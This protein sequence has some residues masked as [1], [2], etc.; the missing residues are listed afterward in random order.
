MRLTFLAFLLVGACTTSPAPP[1]P[2]QVAATIE[3]AA[4]APAPRLPS[5][6]TGAR[7]KASGFATIL[8]APP[9]PYPDAPPAPPGEQESQ[10]LAR[11]QG[12]SVSHAESMMN[13]DESAMRAAN[14][15]RRRLE[16]EAAGNY[17]DVQIVRD[18]RPR[19]QFHFRSDGPETLARFTRDPRFKGVTGGVAHSELAP[20]MQQWFARFEPY[21]LS[22]A[23][24]ANPFTGMIEIEIAVGASE[25]EAIAAR[26]GWQLP[27][28][29][30]LK[31]QPEIDPATTLAPDAAPFV[32]T[33]PRAD[34]APAIIL[35]SASGGRII[36]HDGCFRMNEPDGPLVLFGRNMRLLRDDQGYLALESIGEPGKRA[37]IGEEM[38]W[39]GYPPGVE[40][41]PGV[42]AIRRHCGSGPIA[43]VGEPESAAS[44]RVRSHAIAAYA[45]E[46]RL[47][48]Q[49][50]W[51]EIKACWAAQ[52][53]RRASARPSDSPP[54]TKECDS[55][56]PINPPPPARRR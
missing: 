33:F 13:P 40:E 48:L 46:R 53:A 9:V 6:P 1:P 54:Y 31:F 49:A 29:V 24:G 26:E 20:V 47:T 12:V 15:L 8:S 5:P 18:P 35:T 4:Q 21:R 2:V 25:Y 44:F 14:A 38:I 56:G 34:R 30:T 36:L 27:P 50:A 32:R 52:D 42:Q 45:Q 11:E 41:E 17:V 10:R 51:D 22:S 3:P 28:N 7:I 43:S 16:R 39:G 55:P 37:R 23:G 19:Y